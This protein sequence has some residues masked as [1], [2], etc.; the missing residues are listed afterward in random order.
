MAFLAA[1]VASTAVATTAGAAPTFESHWQDGKAELDG[2]R[3]NVTRY[4]QPR[5]GTAVMVFVTEPLLV[6]KVKLP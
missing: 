2:Y 4:G 6:L 5:H 1:V 3:Y